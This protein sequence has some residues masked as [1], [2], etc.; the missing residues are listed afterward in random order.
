MDKMGR[1]VR[2]ESCVICQKRSLGLD[3]V[4]KLKRIVK[5]NQMEKCIEKKV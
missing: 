5:G 3:F 1:E 4:K 2:S